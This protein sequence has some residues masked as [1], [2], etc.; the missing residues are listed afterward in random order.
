MSFQAL[1]DNTCTIK[2]KS[3]TSDGQGGYTET[4]NTLY[5]NVPCR[6]ESKPRKLEILAYGG[7]K[8]VYPDYIVYIESRSGVKEQHHIIFEGRTF[9]IKLIEDWSEQGKY[10]SLH[11]VEIER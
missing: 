3:L 7:A 2:A 11:V 1:L 9:E 10:M 6:F 4:Y 5:T 8:E